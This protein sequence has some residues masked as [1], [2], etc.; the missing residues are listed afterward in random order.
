MRARDFLCGALFELLLLVRAVGEALMAAKEAI[1]AVIQAVTALQDWRG[2]S[3]ASVVKWL[4]TEK[5]LDK[6]EAAKLVA[7]GVKAG[8]ATGQL[9]LVKQSVHI[10]GVSFAKPADITLGVEVLQP[11]TDPASPPARAGDNV[12]VAYEGRLQTTGAVFDSDKSFTF[13]LGD[14]EVI[15]AWDEGV[16]GM[17]VGEQR[18][19]TCPPKLAYGKRGSPPDI[20]A[21][22][23]LV[24][25]VTLLAAASS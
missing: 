14:G 21:D 7:D 6:V 4:T 9:T 11:P 13:A 3:K 25:D 23:T 8:A 19:L 5:K 18:R 1:E 22:A 15:K 24:F 17:R 10:T 2:S 12:R 20:P 16:V